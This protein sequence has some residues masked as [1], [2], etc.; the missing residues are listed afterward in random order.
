MTDAAIVRRLDA[1]IVL[2]LVIL[3]VLLTPVL[4]TV[5]L[6]GAAVPFLALAAA[7]AWALARDDR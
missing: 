1:I 3:A 5:L 4:P 7:F 6:Y 2:L